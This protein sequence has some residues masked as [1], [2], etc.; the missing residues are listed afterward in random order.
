MSNSRSMWYITR[1]YWFWVQIPF[2]GSEGSFSP[3]RPLKVCIFF[4]YIKFLIDGYITRPYWFWAPSSVFGLWGP[5]LAFLT[6]KSIY[7]LHLYKISDRLMGHMIYFIFDP[8]S[9]QPM[10][11]ADT[12][13]FWAKNTQH[14]IT[15]YSAFLDFW[16][17]WSFAYFLLTHKSSLSFHTF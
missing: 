9:A 10:D 1:P 12:K 3:F 11:P 8:P 15:K 17:F 13:F 16:N 5:I 4:I 14:Q 2:L 7:F 6:P